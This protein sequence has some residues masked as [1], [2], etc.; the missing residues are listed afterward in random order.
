MANTVVLDW[1]RFFQGEIVPKE[2]KG[3]IAPKAFAATWALFT[4]MKVMAATGTE[5]AAASQ[6]WNNVFHTAMGIS[7]WLCV[8]VFIFAGATWMLSHRTD[9]LNRMIGGA[10]GYVVI[11]H[12]MDI[13][14]WLASL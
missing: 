12:S 6:T 3:S 13:Q 11:R 5:S 4:P 8:G 1:D 10:T 9:A 7:D 14:H 2:M